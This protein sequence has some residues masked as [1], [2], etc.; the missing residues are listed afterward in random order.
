MSAWTKLLSVDPD[1]AHHYFEV[2]PAA[3]FPA[4]EMKFLGRPTFLHTPNFYSH[5]QLWEE[6][7]E[8]YPPLPL[9]KTCPRYPEGSAAYK[10]S[11]Q[12]AGED[13]TCCDMYQMCR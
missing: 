4:W 8:D 11:W 3:E 12:V 10:D 1:L 5:L 6:H 2:V 9:R 7:R 13:V